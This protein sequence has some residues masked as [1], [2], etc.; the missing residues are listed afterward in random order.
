MVI[1]TPIPLSECLG[2]HKAPRKTRSTVVAV[3]VVAVV[4]DDVVVVSQYR[5]HRANQQK[6]FCFVFSR[7][8]AHTYD[9]Q[10]LDQGVGRCHRD[11]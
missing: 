7:P 3:A 8:W 9:P 1:R 6:S 11:S 5:A 4:V 10:A 2:G